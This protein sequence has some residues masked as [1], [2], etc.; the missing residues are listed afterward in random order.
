MKD[1]QLAG[2]ILITLIAAFAGYTVAQNALQTAQTNNVF[3]VVVNNT[4]LGSNGTHE[5]LHNAVYWANASPVAIY[6]TLHAVGSGAAQNFDANLSINGT[7][8][9][10]RDFKTS[11]GAGQHDHFSF[12][13]IVPKNANYSFTNSTNVASLEWREYPILSGKNGTLSINQTSIVNL[14]EVNASL[15]YLNSSKWNKTDT[16]NKD[17]MPSNVS[18]NDSKLGM[19]VVKK[20]GFQSNIPSGVWT[21]VT[22]DTELY[23]QNNE[24]SNNNYTAPLSGWY[25]IITSIYVTDNGAADYRTRLYVNGVS[26][27]YASFFTTYTTGTDF[28]ILNTAIIHLNQNDVVGLYFLNTLAAGTTDIYH[29]E[30]TY[31][32]VLLLRR[33]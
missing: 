4:D 18:F 23:D 22:F 29:G 14:G 6:I 26:S 5:R 10:D 11:A 21:L 33:G 1:K 19:V 12:Y 17:Y 24:F 30:G 20:S 31:F 16:L 27:G 8:V 7:I 15:N 32:N 13:T 3:N 9:M 28:T 25:Q 2:L